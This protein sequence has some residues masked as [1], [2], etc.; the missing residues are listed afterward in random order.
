MNA[1]PPFDHPYSL[2]MF[3]KHCSLPCITDLY[4]NKKSSVLW[5][6]VGLDLWE[7]VVAPSLQTTICSIG[8]T[9][10]GIHSST[11]CVIATVLSKSHCSTPC[12]FRCDCGCHFPSTFICRM[13]LPSLICSLNSVNNYTNILPIKLFHYQLQCVI[14]FLLQ[15]HLIQVKILKNI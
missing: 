2:A 4:E 11:C 14:C 13:L 3:F 7:G 12:H 9:S 1:Y 5:S 10:S 8:P 6:P 15:L